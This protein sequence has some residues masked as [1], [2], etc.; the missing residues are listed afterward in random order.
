MAQGVIEV[1][2][3]LFGVA[4]GTLAVLGL[5]MSRP[6]LQEEDEENQITV[7]EVDPFFY[8]CLT[9]MGPREGIPRA[10]KLAWQLLEDQVIA[11]TGTAIGVFY[12]D[13]DDPGAEAK[14]WDIGFPITP[15]TQVLTPL[16]LKKWTHTSVV[17]AYHFGALTKA[18]QTYD[19]VKAWMD[20]NGYEQVGPVLEMYFIGPPSEVPPE[21]YKTR[22]W[23]P[24]AP[25]KP[26]A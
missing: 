2:K 11:P 21:E 26:R 20:A 15:Q 17:E 9:Q 13:P 4:A 12:N 7:K 14:M 1:K 23:V 5:L 22:I 25:K 8:C 18:R 10:V 24:C 6:V 3:R 16:T 19:R